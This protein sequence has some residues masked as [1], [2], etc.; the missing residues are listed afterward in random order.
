MLS[1]L[2]ETFE[3]INRSVF[4]W[5][6]T[7]EEHRDDILDSCASAIPNAREQM[8]IKSL[9]G[10]LVS[11]MVT[12]YQASFFAGHQFGIQQQDWPLKRQSLSR[13]K[14][15]HPSMAS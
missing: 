7:L 4:E 9:Y 2:E 13:L 15:V 6:Y 5:L 8:N 10:Y 3:R 11:F 1:A 12:K 14:V